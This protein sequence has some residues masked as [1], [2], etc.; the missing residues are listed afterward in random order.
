MAENDQEKTEQKSRKKWEE[1]RDKGELPRSQEIATFSVFLIVLLYFQLVKTAWFYNFGMIMSDLLTFDRHLG[2]DLESLPSFMLRPVLRTA[3]ILAPFFGVIL[4]VSILVNMG[5]T[6]FTLAK[7]K[8]KFD[9]KKLDPAKGLKKMFSLRSSVEGLKS[10]AKIALFIWIGFFTI[11]GALTDLTEL[12]AHDVDHQ[13]NYMLALVLKLGLR[14]V[15]VMAVLAAADYAYQWWQFQE[16]LKMTPKE[17]KDEQKEQEGDPLI[18]Q[19]MRTLRMEMSRNRMMGE[20]P[21]AQVVVTNPTHYSV[22]LKYEQG[23]MGAPVVVAK[24]SRHLAFKIRE[25][26]K[27]NGVPIVEHP[28]M[29]RALFRRVP[30]G[31]GVPQEF[32]RVIAELLAYVYMLKTRPGGAARVARGPLTP[33]LKAKLPDSVVAQ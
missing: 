25:I 14:I 7:D 33:R 5:Q 10:S 21:G 4:A 12:P 3:A 31:H 16:K 30:V 26:A 20:V 1:S 19:R 18:R 11:K 28:Q 13:I 27:Q 32:F 24:G 29:A 8:M 23:S 15:I 6:G 9:L 2:I 22:A 17:V